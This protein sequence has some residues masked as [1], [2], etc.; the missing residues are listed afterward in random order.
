ML[1]AA[2]WLL[3]ERRKGEGREEDRE[4]IN[5][6]RVELVRELEFEIWVSQSLRFLSLTSTNTATSIKLQNFE[7]FPSFEQ[8]E[9]TK[10]E[11]PSQDRDYLLLPL[12]L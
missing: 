3:F 11:T 2:V 1:L 9:R 5:S 10:N 6:R 8:K 4:S 7:K 12:S